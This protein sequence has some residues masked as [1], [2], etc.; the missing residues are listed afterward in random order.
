MT[1]KEFIGMLKNIFSTPKTDREATLNNTIINRLNDLEKKLENRVVKH[2]EDN[3]RIIEYDT[4]IRYCVS[5]NHKNSYFYTL[6]EARKYRDEVLKVKDKAL[7]SRELQLL[8][9]EIEIKEYPYNAL[10]VLIE[11]YNSYNTPL[12]FDI[13]YVLDNFDKH[14]EYIF[15]NF[16][17]TSR[18][19]TVFNLRF[20]ELKTLEQTGQ[21]IGV[22]RERIRQTEAKTIR[23]LRHPSRL[24]II[25][26]GI[27]SLKLEEDIKMLEAELALKKAN[28][29]KEINRINVE[30][31]SSKEIEEYKNS[32][33]YILNTKIENLDL[34]VRSYNCLRRSN[35]E[36]LGDIVSMTQEDLIKIRNLGRRSFKEIIDK[37]KGFGFEL[38]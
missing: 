12:D 25:L 3:I 21:I 17:F 8:K 10:D 5:I 6:E 29:L 7:A 31:L 13:N 22:T 19:Q 1:D 30:G 4:G 26:Y 32:E 20:K 2:I 35:I 27:D 14:I 37:C 16:N 38:R 9:K 33:E 23:K 18:E 36:T 24:K 15:K 11:T 34:S 28:I